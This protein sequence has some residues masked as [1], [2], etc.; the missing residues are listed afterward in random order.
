MAAPGDRLFYP[1]G[2]ALRRLRMD[3]ADEDGPDEEPEGAG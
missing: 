3:S 2:A 1:L